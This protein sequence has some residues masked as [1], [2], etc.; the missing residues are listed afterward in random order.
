MKFGNG[1]QAAFLEADGDGVVDARVFVIGAER[2]SLLELGFGSGE[3]LLGQKYQ[4][5]TVVEF[6]V[7]GMSGQSGCEDFA[8]L[9]EFFGF[10]QQRSEKRGRFGIIRPG[11]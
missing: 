4:A 2:E 7:L 6:G 8:G 9:G 1:F 11:S 10:Q 3:L 5:G